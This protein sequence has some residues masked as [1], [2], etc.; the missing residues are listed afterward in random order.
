MQNVF[1]L[2]RGALRVE[3][4]GGYA[5]KKV[6]IGAV[7]LE[8]Q[9]A[10][11][12]TRGDTAGRGSTSEAVRRACRV[13][14][15]SLPPTIGADSRSSTSDELWSCRRPDPLADA[16]AFWA[17]FSSI[18]LRPD[19]AGPSRLCLYFAT[20]QVPSPATR[21][22]AHS[23]PCPRLAQARCKPVTRA[24][25]C[26]RAQHGARAVRVRDARDGARQKP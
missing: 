26:V 12:R 9:L 13:G 22:H 23:S 18:N 4:S 15:V 3:V 20:S 19:H 5:A 6:C 24:P 16:G 21:A 1:A 10:Q 25:P 17:R 11:R 8:P 2:R 7:R 14:T